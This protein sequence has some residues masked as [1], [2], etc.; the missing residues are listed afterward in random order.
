[1]AD[2]TPA[3]NEIKVTALKQ[4]VEA[5]VELDKEGVFNP[6]P[7]AELQNTATGNGA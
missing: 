1:M 4:A 7:E 2:F 6:M 3:A 5:I